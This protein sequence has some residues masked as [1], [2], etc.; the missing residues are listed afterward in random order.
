M[1]CFVNTLTTNVHYSR[2][3]APLNSHNFSVY[4][5]STS[6]HSEYFEHGI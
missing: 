4:I 6:I 5:Y 1:L 2:R 3:T